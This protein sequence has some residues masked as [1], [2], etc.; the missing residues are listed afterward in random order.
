MALSGGTLGCSF[1]ITPEAVEPPPTK[2][3]T[4]AI[5]GGRSRPAANCPPVPPR[6]GG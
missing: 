4:V 5:R 1:S 3:S 6:V 2:I